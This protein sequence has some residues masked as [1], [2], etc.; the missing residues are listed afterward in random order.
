MADMLNAAE[1][2]DTKSVQEGLAKGV[3]VN[4]RTAVRVK[5]CSLK[6]PCFAL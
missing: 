5:R 6:W 1:K 4:T 3:D 2:G